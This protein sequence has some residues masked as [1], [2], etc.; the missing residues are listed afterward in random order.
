MNLFVAGLTFYSGSDSAFPAVL[1]LFFI[2]LDILLTIEP[3]SLADCS[4]F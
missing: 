2:A 1:I 4:S 3:S